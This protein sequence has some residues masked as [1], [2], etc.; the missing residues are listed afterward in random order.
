MTCI[1]PGSS[2]RKKRLRIAFVLLI[3][4][5][6]R[7]KCNFLQLVAFL[8]VSTSPGGKVLLL[9]DISRKCAELCGTTET[10]FQASVAWNHR[11]EW[12]WKEVC[13][14]EI[15][16][17]DRHERLSA[18]FGQ[19]WEMVPWEYTGMYAGRSQVGNTEWEMRSMKL[20]GQDLP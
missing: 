12:D 4:L 14:G 6:G 9:L 18:Y 15:N 3:C 2:N 7:R 5:F 10:E 1:L 17:I 20:I 8:N 19:L 16:A 13:C 11:K